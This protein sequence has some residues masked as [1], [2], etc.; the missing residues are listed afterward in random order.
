M[1]AKLARVTGWSQ[2]AV[3]VSSSS[4]PP[5]DHVTIGKFT[6]VVTVQGHTQHT[7][8][9]PVTEAQAGSTTLTLRLANKENHLLPTRSSLNVVGTHFG[10]LAIVIISIAL[11]VFVLTAAARAIRR[12]RPQEEG[13]AAEAEELDAMPSTRDPAS[14][15]DEPDT[16]IIRGVDDRQPAR[17]ADEHASTPGA[18]DRS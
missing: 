16:V 11:V 8:K 7:I 6:D 17:E 2:G 13:S 12:D 3:T 9:I 15:G 4:A 1:L 10:T 18:A 5:A 14:A